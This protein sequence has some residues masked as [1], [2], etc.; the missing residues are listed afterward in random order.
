[1]ADKKISD[2]ICGG[3]SSSS[4]SVGTGGVVKLPYGEAITANQLVKLNSSGKVVGL[5]STTT[6]T[7]TTVASYTGDIAMGGD[8]VYKNWT[9]I[10]DDKMTIISAYTK[11][12]TNPLATFYYRIGKLNADSIVWGTEQTLTFSSAVYPI[13][14]ISCG[15]DRFV[16]YGTDVVASTAS[17]SALSIRTCMVKINS[18]TM[19]P[20][21]SVSSGCGMSGFTTAS[22]YDARVCYL[23]NDRIAFFAHVGTEIKAWVQN[24]DP[25]TL[26]YSNFGSQVSFASDAVSPIQTTGSYIRNMDAVSARADS[27]MV[28]YTGSSSMIAKA[29]YIN[30]SVASTCAGQ[31]IVGGTAGLSNGLRLVALDTI[32]TYLF[33]GSWNSNFAF[34]F[35]KL[36]FPSTNALTFSTMVYDTTTTLWTSINTTNNIE[37]AKINDSMVVMNVVDYTGDFKTRFID[38]RDTV[39]ARTVYSV[40]GIVKRNAGAIGIFMQYLYA[41]GSGRWGMVVPNGASDAS[42]YPFIYKT[43]TMGNVTTYDAGNCIGVASETGVL[44]EEKSV[45]IGSSVYAGFTGLTVGATYYINPSTGTITTTASNYPLGVALSSTKLSLNMVR[46]NFLVNNIIVNTVND[47]LIGTTTT[48]NYVLVDEGGSGRYSVYTNNTLRQT[49]D[50]T[51]NITYYGKLNAQGNIATAPTSDTATG[52]AGD[53]VITSSGDMYFCYATNAWKKITSTTF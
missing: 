40:T 49:M 8:S 5:T 29:L 31:T 4:S 30:G 35:Q 45:Y 7:G 43:F 33:V 50:K 17:V 51:G 9:A 1:M 26:V 14:L 6:G 32:G 2:L 27:C 25:S 11:V 12:S 34:G 20:I 42:A 41:D 24:I 44:D 52:V 36:Y 46:N 21:T 37:L 15:V 23:G 13:G 39:L 28:A 48:S 3:S 47:K 38:I 16:L 19:L 18:S 10:L 53:F 22:Y